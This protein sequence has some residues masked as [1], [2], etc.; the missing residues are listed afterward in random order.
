MYKNI[1]INLRVILTYIK[2]KVP[3][4]LIII[5]MVTK[6]KNFIF[7]LYNKI[8]LK[9]LLK[10]TYKNKLISETWST[11]NLSFWFYL[12]KKFF[13]FNKKYKILEIGSYEGAS[14]IF[15]LD[16]L[17]NSKIYCVDT[18]SSRFRFGV[19]KKN[20]NYSKIE[21]RFDYNLQPYKK[22][23]H[24]FKKDSSLFF[25][26]INKDLLFDL[27][28][29]DGSHKYK[30]VLNDAR[31]GFDHLKNEGIIIFDDFNKPEVLK[32]AMFFL[33]VNQKKIKILM[34]YHQLVIKKLL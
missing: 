5:Y 26:K 34:V 25:K 2:H 32:A 23:V 27:I 17:K 22:R 19:T 14:S 1:Y 6:I 11:N 21:K 9:F 4:K 12:L 31:N 30:D 20:I 18:W 10:K 24:K 8:Y 13:N 33:N 28:Y 29:I 7:R 15:F 16:I 3:L